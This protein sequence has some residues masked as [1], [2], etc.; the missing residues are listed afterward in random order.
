MSIQQ[1]VYKSFK[2]RS[3]ALAIMLAAGLI[4][5]SWKSSNVHPIKA[6]NDADTGADYQVTVSLKTEQGTVSPN[7]M[8][9]N[10]EY[11]NEKDVFWNK[12]DGPFADKIK[13]LKPGQLRWPGGTL[14][15][16]YH[17]T[18]LNGVQGHKDSWAPEYNTSKDTQPANYMDIDEYLA[19]AKKLG[20][21]LLIGINMGSG[22]KFDKQKDGID[23]AKALVLKVKNY[24]AAN[25]PK[26]K[27]YFYLDNEPYQPDANY[28]YKTP[29]DY[30]NEINAYTP[31]LKSIDPDIKTIAN[32]KNEPKNPV[33]VPRLIKIAGANIDYID[34]HYYWRWSALSFD[35]WTQEAIMLNQQ[36]RPFNQERAALK[37]MAAA[38]GHPNIDLVA[39][40]WNLGR[41][42]VPGAPVPTESQVALMVAEQFTEFVQSGMP[43]A[44]FWPIHFPRNPAWNRA[45]LDATQD[46]STNKVYDMFKLFTDIPNGMKVESTVKTITSGDENRI[47]TLAV[48][49]AGDNTLYVYLINKDQTKEAANIDIGIPGFQLK[50]A[51]VQ[52]FEANDTG[53]GNL[54]IHK[55]NTVANHSATNSHLKFSMPKNSFVKVMIG[56]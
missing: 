12:G 56:K 11:D 31:A 1:L 5:S 16:F 32:A 27:K 25:M 47:R 10:L 30:A 20:S 3:A 37:A 28:N 19:T 54:N 24:V 15:T 39:F 22:K 53:H 51:V 48:R 13:V 14:T 41:K 55:I 50:T 35:L 52:C 46:Y 2:N 26:A 42:M 45:V 18:R 38:N 43:M 7:L 21:D 36:S 9:F 34:I 6:V 33:W 49:N 17:W 4:I 23:E 40:E 8:G 29:D 44:C